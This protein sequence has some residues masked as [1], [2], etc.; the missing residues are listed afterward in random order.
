MET[1]VFAPPGAEPVGQGALLLRSPFDLPTLLD[2][3]PVSA[4]EHSAVQAA[5]TAVTQ[6]LPT[7]V[8]PAPAPTPT[9]GAGGGADLE[10]IYEHVVDRLRRDL[11]VER[12]RMGDLVGDLP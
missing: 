5:E 10:A 12:E 2:S 11:L 6:H 4:L 7:P 3:E 9:T 1:V 8:P